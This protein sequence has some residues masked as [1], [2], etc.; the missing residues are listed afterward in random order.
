MVC[1]HITT[2][3]LFWQRTLRVYAVSEE[4]AR[5]I[6]RYKLRFLER[7]QYIHP[8]YFTPGYFA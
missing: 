3:C 2:R 4:G 5:R 8:D 6:V 7:V 1:W